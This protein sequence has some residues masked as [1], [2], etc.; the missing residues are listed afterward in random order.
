MWLFG[1]SSEKDDEC[2]SEPVG[3]SNLV[4]VPDV[5]E[6]KLGQTL[7]KG[8]FGVV[9]EARNVRTGELVAIKI[10]P[11]DKADEKLEAEIV[12][13]QRLHHKHVV[14]ILE[15]I[16]KDG[17]TYIVMELVAGG[18]LFDFIVKNVRIPEATVRRI[19]QEII[20]G[21]EHC[22]INKVAHRD[23]KPENI[24]LDSSQHVKLGDFG[25]SGEMQEGVMMTTSCG[26]PNYAAPELLSKNCQYE[27]P[28]VDIWSSGVI[29]YALLCNQLPFDADTMGDLFK[30]IKRGHYRVP[31]TVSS[32]AKDLIAQMLT[33]DRTQR[34]SIDGIKQHPWFAKDLPSGLF[35]FEQEEQKLEEEPDDESQP[36]QKMQSLLEFTLVPILS[37]ATL[38]VFPMANDKCQSAISLVVSPLC[39]E[40]QSQRKTSKRRS[41]HA[42]S[43]DSVR[44]LA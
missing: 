39:E 30:L 16:R 14:E 29:L 36:L 15:V 34:I 10:I 8:S 32:E 12:N 13:Q 22:H 43:A 41:Y 18:D 2:P 37:T 35:A 1:Y 6:Y 38:S 27:G 19:F 40:K 20:S 21:V 26:S 31:G 28:D 23:L 17:D 42:Y 44:Q 33:V 25:L 4:D 11:A 9:K 3:E 24:F 5:G 7:G